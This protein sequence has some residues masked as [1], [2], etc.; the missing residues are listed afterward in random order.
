MANICIL[1]SIVLYL[2]FMVG[3]GAWYT[4]RNTSADD[5]YYNFLER[6]IF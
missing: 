4:K 3:V 2:A 1:I 6:K 5:F